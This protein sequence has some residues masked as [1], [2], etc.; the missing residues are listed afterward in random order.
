[1]SASLADDIETVIA[2]V[3]DAQ[4]ALLKLVVGDQ[5]KR[6]AHLTSGA[7]MEALVVDLMGERQVLRDLLAECRH[8]IQNV[9]QDS[10]DTHEAERLYLLRTQIDAALHPRVTPVE[11][12][13]AK[14]R[15][16]R[17]QQHQAPAE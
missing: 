1:M 7:D 12:R 8:F 3:K 4:Q 6:L 9:W 16:Q 14:A 17:V 10:D 2:V 13:V 11:M 5:L 15:R